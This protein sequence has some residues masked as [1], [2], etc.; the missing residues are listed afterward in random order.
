M[1]SKIIWIVVIV[2]AA[3]GLYLAINGRRKPEE[4]YRTAAI[5]QGYITQ[6]VAA[7]GTLSAVTTVQVGSQVSGIIAK[8]YAD[9]NS[10]VKKGQLLAELDETPFKE[11]IEQNVAALEKAK[12]E[13]R[14]AEISLR[15]QKA[16]SQQGLAPQADIDQAQANYDAARASVAQAQAMLN[17]A[18]TDL[19]N[20]KIKAPIDGVVVSRQYD[21]GQTVAASF[22]AP[23]L[24]TIAQDLTKMQV[25]ADISESDIG[26][27]KVAEPVRFNVDAY[28][29]RNFRGKVAQVRLNATVN[30]NVV[31]YPVI[32]EVNNE[33][34]LLKP[35]M[36]ANVTI[37]V[38]SA[39][40]VLRVP[41]A[42]LRFRPEVKEGSDK[43]ATAPDRS[44][45]AGGTSG[46]NRA[47]AAGQSSEA[48]QSAPAAQPGGPGAG[49]P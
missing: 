21:V 42:A 41:N 13:M 40:N 33:D 4:K 36:T 3:V 46:G 34:L 25:S 9:F 38:A 11:K 35:T 27:I 48:A 39:K 29:D 10:Q 28:P 17:Q 30:Q 44:A 22:Q 23:T 24:F 18:Q 47:G 8:L 43:P 49:S 26:Q 15:R 19:H 45:G 7:T 31:T 32:V 37:D 12:V 2:V 6:T 5:D 14:N 20:S 16:L 1:K